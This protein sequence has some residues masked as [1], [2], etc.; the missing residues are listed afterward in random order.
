VIATFSKKKVFG[1]VPMIAAMLMIGL[2][3]F[4]V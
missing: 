1:H 4:I 3:G 2:I